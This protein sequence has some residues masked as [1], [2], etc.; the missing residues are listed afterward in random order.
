MAETTNQLEHKKLRARYHELED[1]LET[2]PAEQQAEIRAEMGRV[3][4]LSGAAFSV[5][6]AEK[7]NAMGIKA[8][9]F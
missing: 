7:M 8:T 1:S 3:L 5:S 4:E 2:A 9:P 6:L